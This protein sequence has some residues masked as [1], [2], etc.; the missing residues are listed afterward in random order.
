MRRLAF[1]LVPAAVWL[2]SAT[3]EPA[4]APHP[5][6]A[7]PPYDMKAV[8]LTGQPA[9]TG[10]TFTGFSDPAINNRGHVAFAALTSVPAAHT[11]VYLRADG[12]LRALAIAGRPA[13]TGGRFTVF[14]DVILS[15]RDTVGFLGR[16]S[17]RLAHQGLYLTRGGPIAAVVATGQAAPGGG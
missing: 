16:T 14:N 6:H 13:P 1:F 7:A 12:R 17:D 11:A 8:L 15:D 5:A 3:I 4:D 2:A 10:G 9:P